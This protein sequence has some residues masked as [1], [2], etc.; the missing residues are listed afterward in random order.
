MMAPKQRKKKEK[1]QH[2]NNNKNNNNTLFIIT[3]TIIIH[4]IKQLKHITYIS[5]PFAMRHADDGE[6]EQTTS[7]YIA[8]AAFFN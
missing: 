1:N 4:N 8:T 5:A 2:N 7:T 3:T 6:V